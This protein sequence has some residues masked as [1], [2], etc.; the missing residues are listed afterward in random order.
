ML[1]STQLQNQQLIMAHL[2][3]Y[4]G[5]LDG[6]WGPQ[7]IQAKKDWESSGKF[8]PAFPNSGMPLDPRG[9]LPTGIIRGTA[10][11]LKCLS[12]TSEKEAELL[13]TK[14]ELYVGKVEPKVKETPQ[15]IKPEV[16]SAPTPQVQASDEPTEAVEAKPN[17]E[18]A[19][20][21]EKKPS[22]N[23]HHRHQQKKRRG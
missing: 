13:S 10:G 3:F 20:P 21:V 16:V 9:K 17:T 2:G 22:N 14:G 15:E 1:K 5:K 7:A 6:V 12:L 8:K 18:Q 19:Q 23:P 4:R 11:L